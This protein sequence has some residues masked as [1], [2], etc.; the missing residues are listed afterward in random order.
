METYG[1]LSICS[2]PGGGEVRQEMET[3]EEENPDGK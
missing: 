1:S 3:G 2:G